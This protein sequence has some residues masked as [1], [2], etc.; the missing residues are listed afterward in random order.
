[1]SFAEAAEAKPLQEMQLKQDDSAAIDYPLAVNKFSDVTHLTFYFPSNFGSDKTR[2]YY[3]GLR[4]EYKHD[5]REQ[6][7]I[8]SK[9]VLNQY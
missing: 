4:G 6:V 3:I 9:I 7:Y 8:F 5:V 1:M 2:L